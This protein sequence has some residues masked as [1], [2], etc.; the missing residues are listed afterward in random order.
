MLRILNLPTLFTSNFRILYVACYDSIR[1]FSTVTG[2]IVRELSDNKD[3]KIVGFNIE[4]V[5]GK[6]LIACTQNGTIITWKLDSY[7]IANKLVSL[8]EFILVYHLFII[9]IFAET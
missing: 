7:I 1:L 2:E 9:L 4:P 6:S 5:G 8:I 3:G